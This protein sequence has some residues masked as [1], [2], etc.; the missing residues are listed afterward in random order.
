LASASGDEPTIGS[1]FG[2]GDER[3]PEGFEEH[4]QEF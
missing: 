4:E 3:N 2:G 1:G